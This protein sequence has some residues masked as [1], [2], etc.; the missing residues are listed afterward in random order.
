MV[1]GLSSWAGE[2][3]D[4]I[5]PESC[6]APGA[7]LWGRAQEESVGS[8]EQEAG[9]RQREGQPVGRWGTGRSEPL[10]GL[11]QAGAGLGAG[12]MGARAKDG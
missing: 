4:C 6:W 2:K 10:R 5:S 8:R 3:E 9:G 7:C 11:S 1:W 12:G